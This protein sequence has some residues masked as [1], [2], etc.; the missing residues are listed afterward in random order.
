MKSLKFLCVK[1][2][3]QDQKPIFWFKNL[4]YWLTLEK[5]LLLHNEC[6][7][8]FGT[9]PV[10]EKRVG[11][12]VKRFVISKFS[13]L[14]YFILKVNSLFLLKSNQREKNIYTFF[15]VLATALIYMLQ[16]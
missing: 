14:V 5:I 4:E 6:L 10:S 9:V 16:H 11:I 13:F 3:L 2:V 1:V 7:S 15:F 8:F 12:A